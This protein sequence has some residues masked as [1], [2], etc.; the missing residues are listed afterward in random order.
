MN[1]NQQIT[2]NYLASLWSFFASIRLTV[3]V[4]LS[5]A[6]LSII[7][8]LIPQNESPAQYF[9]AFGPFLYRVMEILDI[10]DMYR[11]WWFQSLII[12]LVVN[13]LVC[14]IDRLQTTGKIIFD[15]NPKFNLDNY[16]RRKS[17]QDFRSRMD[18]ETCKTTFHQR[19]SRQFGYCRVE[20]VRQGYA[21]TAEKGRWTRLGVYGV[22]F[23][24]VVLLIGALVGSMTGF[25]GY[26]N[27]PEGEATDTIHL[28]FSGLPFKLPFAIRCEDFD[29]QFYKTGAP[30]EFRSKLVLLEGG[31][32]VLNKDVI[33]ND[34]IR[35]KGINIFQSSYGKL[36]GD[37][38][39]AAPPKEFELTFKSAASGMIYSIKAG[40][41]Q[42]IEVPEGLG[43][44]VVDGFKPAAQFQGMAIGPALTG[45]L[46]PP[47]GKPQSVVLP[48]KFPK[49]DAMRR[50]TVIIA[51]VHAE[52]PQHSRYYTGL[53]VTRDPGVGLVY[54][55]FVLMILGC[56][57]TFFMAHQQVVVEI[58]PHGKGVSVM[59]SGRANRNKVGMQNDL[60]RL[61]HKLAEM[62][63]EGK[64]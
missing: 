53:Q 20:S 6:A 62:A 46:T 40:L 59:V 51:V 36:D 11:S 27:I 49:F 54:F 4:L 13:I 32:P 15:R 45:T 37:N 3:V 12:L 55:G 9:N 17:R 58:Q 48:L 8:T 24:I 1:K 18:P 14:S 34:P 25:E 38:P 50:G 64:E 47:Q 23:S 5:L 41:N 63:R 52:N 43:T 30:R 16:R 2:G 56:M 29:V 44:F 60:E 42:T 35:Y 31:Q 57:V 10:F 19:L 22:H 61:A 39:A 21:I 7:G 28:R 33:V 26:V